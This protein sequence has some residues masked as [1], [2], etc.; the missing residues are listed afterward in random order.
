MT[1]VQKQSV[2]EKIY[3]AALDIFYEKGYKD[4]TMREIAEKAE[5]PVGLIYT[6]FKNKADLFDY[7][8]APVLHY[9]EKSLLSNTL[10]DKSPLDKLAES[11]EEDRRMLVQLMNSR[12]EMVI[13][14][15][16]SAGTKYENT[17]DTVISMVQTHIN[18]ERRKIVSNYEDFHGAILATCFVESIMAVARNYQDKDWARRMV[19][20]ISDLL[21]PAAA[22]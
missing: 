20:Y 22:C 2:K 13:A 11:F 21:F 12:K 6:Y 4:T 5:I 18:R 14:I 3:E 9:V 16:K 17:K 10:P 19:V 8:V 7:I 15:D 1:Q